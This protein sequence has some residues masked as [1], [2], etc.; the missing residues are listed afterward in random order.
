[1]TMPERA[2]NLMRK[3]WLKNATQENMLTETQKPEAPNPGI[4]RDVN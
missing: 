4:F 3:E 1:M 2:D